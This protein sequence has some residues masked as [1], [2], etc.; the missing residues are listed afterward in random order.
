MKTFEITREQ[1][2]ALHNACY[3]IGMG[4]TKKGLA[5]LGPV[6]TALME[7]ADEYQEQLDQK[8]RQLGEQ[9]GIKT[10][11]WS[12]QGVDI[13]GPSIVPFGGYV[14]SPYSRERE[15]TQ[16]PSWLDT[17]AAIDRLA[18]REDWGDH[19]VIERVSVDGLISL[20]S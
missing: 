5:L 14:V 12:V 10:T 3:Y 1:I 16:G 13:E 17:W 19:I 11:V 8:T 2:S 15:I 4:E 6:A 7:K 9:R 20:G 18:Q